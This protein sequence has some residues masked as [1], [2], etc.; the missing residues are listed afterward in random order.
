MLNSGYFQDIIFG[1][2]RW[3]TTKPM[4]NISRTEIEAF[5]SKS[6]CDDREQIVSEDIKGAYKV[7]ESVKG[8]AVA[9]L[10]KKMSD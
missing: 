1:T 2:K 5:I 10:H 6:K 4:R 7:Y 9:Y 8:D 3:F